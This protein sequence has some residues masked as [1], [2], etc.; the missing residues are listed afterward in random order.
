MTSFV[1]VGDGG[2]AQAVLEALSGK[3]TASIAAL[4]TSSAPSS[5]LVNFAQKQNIP[6]RPLGLLTDPETVLAPTRE[7]IDWLLSANNTAILSGRVLALFR[8]GAL[9]LH[10]GLLPEY[11]GLH[12]HQWAIRNG[13]KEFGATIHFMEPSVDAG[14][15]VRQKRFPLLSSDTGITVFRRCLRAGV[16]IFIEVIS[17]ILSERPLVSVPQDLTRRVLYRHRDNLDGRIDWNWS[18]PAIEAFVRAGNYEPFRSPSYVA[19]LDPTM[20][21]AIEVLRVEIDGSGGNIPGSIL[22]VTE[23]GLVVAS[24]GGGSIRITRARS[25]EG[26]LDVEKWRNYVAQL[27]NRSLQGRSGPALYMLGP[28]LG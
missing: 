21:F 14:A 12:T 8:C 13:E 16:Q 4:F 24:G 22:E 26:I 23:K 27:P 19:C 1:V 18:A 2:P 17:D 15:I 28:R 3:A 25:K 7:D 9:N 10:P 20:D 5:P 6:V 11:A